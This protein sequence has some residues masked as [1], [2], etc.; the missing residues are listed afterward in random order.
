MVHTFIEE[1]RNSEK[2]LSSQLSHLKTSQT[3]EHDKTEDQGTQ[4][5]NIP[6]QFSDVNLR[7]KYIGLCTFKEKVYEVIFADYVNLNEV[8]RHNSIMLEILSQF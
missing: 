8:L 1:K 2:E 6:E 4:S 7:Y 3:S 5:P